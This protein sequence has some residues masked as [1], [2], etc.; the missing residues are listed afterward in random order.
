[1]FAFWRGKGIRKLILY[2]V[3]NDKRVLYKVI[4]CVKLIVFLVP[5]I[6]TKFLKSIIKNEEDVFI[7]IK[8]VNNIECAVKEVMQLIPEKFPFNS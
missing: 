4:L 5:F 6:G 7:N 8:G 2:E 1:M 3:F